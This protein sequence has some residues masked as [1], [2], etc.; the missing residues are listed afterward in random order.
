MP[1]LSGYLR[2]HDG[3][4]LPWVRFE[5]WAGGGTPP[6]AMSVAPL[7]TIPILV[8]PDR[9]VLADQATDERGHFRVEYPVLNAGEHPFLIY[10]LEDR[11]P[12]H[13]SPTRTAIYYDEART[14][15]WSIRF[16]ALRTMID[17]ASY[18]SDGVRVD[19]RPPRTTLTL[20]GMATTPPSTRVQASVHRAVLAYELLVN[21][22]RWFDREIAAAQRAPTD[23]HPNPKHYQNYCLPTWSPPAASYTNLHR[24]N[25]L[26]VGTTRGNVSNYWHDLMSVEPDDNTPPDNVLSD[27]DYQWV[28]PHEYGHHVFDI[29]HPGY[30]GGTGNHDNYE[31]GYGRH[32]FMGYLADNLAAGGGALGTLW[33]IGLGG[34]ATAFRHADDGAFVQ[35]LGIDFAEG[36]ASYIGKCFNSRRSPDS[37]V[38]TPAP[39]ATGYGDQPT[40]SFLW[41]LTDQTEDHGADHLQIPFGVIHLMCCKWGTELTAGHHDIPSSVT[42]GTDPAGRQGVR[43]DARTLPGFITYLKA[44]LLPRY[45]ARLD[46]M[47]RPNRL[48]GVVLRWNQLRSAAGLSTL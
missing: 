13:T 12:H 24:V 3:V 9:L 41:D 26:Y 22:R 8:M 30:R 46:S 38:E 31:P 1:T 35:Q 2:T 4:G 20:A 48:A 34:V 11:R 27:E 39:D 19:A 25:G 40:L 6:V 43:H 37:E 16:P 45:A 18:L 23:A 42:F 10:Y 44:N 36:Y 17:P 33:T 28:F 29:G 7:S 15:V 14:L 32:Y 21:E 47:V 5:V